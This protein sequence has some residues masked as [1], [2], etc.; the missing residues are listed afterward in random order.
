MNADIARNRQ[1]E[2]VGASSTAEIN[3]PTG[4]QLSPKE[5]YE[6]YHQS[7][8]ST[9]KPWSYKTLAAAYPGNGSD[10]TIM[11]KVNNYAANN[12]LL[13]RGQKPKRR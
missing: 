7:D 11:T 9:G 5:L 10:V 13:V 12:G 3:T 8:P 4:K 2:Q 6:L 1:K